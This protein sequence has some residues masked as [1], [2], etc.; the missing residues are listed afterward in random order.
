MSGRT[1]DVIIVGGGVM[2]C[3]AAYHLAADGRRVMLLEQFTIGH[4]LGSSHG[5]SRMIRLAYDR[6]DYIA[7][8]R[9][10]YPLWRRLETE[11]EEQ[12]LFTI[13]G[14][15]I[16]LPHAHMLAGIRS[17]YQAAGVPFETLDRNEIRRRYPQ[18][19]LPDGIIGYYQPDYGILAA[20]RCVATLAGQARRRGAMFVEGHPVRTVRATSGGVELRTDD[21]AYSADRV[22]LAAGSWMPPLLRAIDVALPLV[23][24][25]EQLAFFTPPDPAMFQADRFPL[26]IH[27]FPETTS[28]GS[29]FPIFFHGGVK[30]MLDRTGPEV[31]PGDPDRGVDESRLAALDAFTAGILPALGGRVAEAI[32]CRYTM[33]P[34]EDF[35]LDLHPA[36]PEIVVASPCSGHGFKFAVVIGRILADL[37]T[38]GTTE[39]PIGAFAL[40]RTALRRPVER[41]S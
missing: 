3:A 7:L 1:A 33:T 28:L 30:M 32:T 11:A 5:P 16:G 25:K 22:I 39:Y 17:T 14:M 21:A 2:G 35:I 6:E 18:F 37:A 27:R 19:S 29:G 15:D 31:D 12:L 13:G 34:D 23:V 41:I 10:S 4:T 9:A 38:R 20:D 26:F 24:K 40:T 8:A 36:Y